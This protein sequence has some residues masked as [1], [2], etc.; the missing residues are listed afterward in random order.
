MP[1]NYIPPARTRMSLEIEGTGIQ[2][3]IMSLLLLPNELLLQISDGLKGDLR[4]LSALVRANRRLARLLAGTLIDHVFST[5]SKT[6]GERALYSAARRG[7]AITVGSL[8]DRGILGFICGQPGKEE[9]FLHTAVQTES[10]D[11]IRTLLACGL[12]PSVRAKYGKTPLSIAAETGNLGAVGALLES[13]QVEV[14]TKDTWGRTPLWLA[15]WKGYSSVVRALLGRPEVEANSQQR[16]TDFN[17]HETPLA[18]ACRCGHVSVVRELLADKRVNVNA[19]DGAG[20]TPIHLSVTNS[21]SDILRLLLAHPSID[22][23]IP[24]ASGRTPL[25]TAAE[26]G[27]LDA[28][29]QF[30]LHPQITDLNILAADYWAPLGLAAWNGREG[31]TA[32]YLAAR[33]MWLRV[34]GE[35]LEAEEV[36]VYKRGAEG[37][38]SFAEFVEG[39]NDSRMKELLR[40]KV[41]SERH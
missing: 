18:I 41:E 23:L 38:M 9:Y 36:D 24:C 35:L 33:R 13:A 3:H 27:N 28:F 34:V 16:N 30:L 32:L 19:R 10:L 5:R 37:G 39:G 25:H 6:Y 15:A 22:A 2:L 21:C 40:G 31:I 1:H 26:L 11:T 14:N 20:F 17:R 4:D 7:D 29:T 8:L 12:P